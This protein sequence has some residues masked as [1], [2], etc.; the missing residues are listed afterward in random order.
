MKSGRVLVVTSC[1]KS[2]K[3]GSQFS[4]VRLVFAVR[5]CPWRQ[6]WTSRCQSS[7][8]LCHLQAG[9]GS[10]EDFATSLGELRHL[11]ILQCVETDWFGFENKTEINR[12]RHPRQAI[13]SALPLY[14][15]APGLWSYHGVSHSFTMNGSCSMVFNIVEPNT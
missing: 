6:G 10:L 3:F 12:Q 5:S 7:E 4:F 2:Q 15:A 11:A 14:A 8:N 13:D 9:S 1:L